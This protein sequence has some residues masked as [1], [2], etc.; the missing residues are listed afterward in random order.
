MSGEWSDDK[1]GPEG[2][3]PGETGSSDAFFW[4]NMT[5]GSESQKGLGGGSIL[6]KLGFLTHISRPF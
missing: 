6:E 5:R 2:F 1:K 3:D 4:S